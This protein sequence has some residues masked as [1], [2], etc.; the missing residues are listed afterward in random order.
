VKEHVGSYEVVRVLARGGMAV[1]YLAVQPTLDRQVALKRLQLETTDPTLAQR[2]VREAKLAA[3]LD[4]PNVVTLFDFFEDGGVPYIAMEYVSGGSLRRLVGHL[5]LPQVFGVLEGVLAGLSHAETRGI[6]HRDL[7][8]ENVLLTRAGGVKIA[9]FGIA[10]AYNALTPS[11]TKTDSAIGTPSYMAPEQVTGDPL[12][13]YTDL[14]A[15]GVIAYELLSGHPPFNTGTPPVAVLYRHVHTPPPPLAELAPDTPKPVCEWAEWLLEKAP[16]ERPASAAAASQALEEIAVETLGPY[17]RRSAAIKPD[18]APVPT[19]ATAVVSTAAP[20]T[21]TTRVERR[22]RR[23][24]RAVLAGVA[25]AAAGAATAGVLIATDNTPTAEAPGAVPAAAA[26]P[27]DFD[28]DGRRELVLGMP[29]SGPSGAGV[30]ATWDGRRASTV[31]TAGDAEIRAPFNGEE[32]FGTSLA[33]SDFNQDGY[34]DL[35]VSVPGRQLVTV[36]YGTSKGLK[37]ADVQRIGTSEMRLP[38]DTG[39]FGSRLVGADFNDDGF[40][41]LV[42]GAPGA[43]PNGTVSSGSLL[44]MF[45]GKDGISTSDT[46]VLPR[47]GELLQF[48]TKLRAGDVDGDRHID[49]VE[50]APDTPR[51]HLTFCPG[52]EDGPTKCRVVTDSLGTSALAVADLTGDGRDDIVQGDHID[53]QAQAT[54]APPSGG[55]IRIWRGRRNGPS[56]TPLTLTQATPNIPGAE[57]S[58]DGFGFTVDTADLDGDSLADIIVG[59]PFDDGGTGSLAIIHGGRGGYALGG[60]TRFQK[61]LGVSG[62]GEPGDRLGWAVSA[63]DF[64]GDDRVDIAV[65]VPGAKRLR[66]AVFVLERSK[67]LFAP[68]DTDVVWP[69]RG[70]KGV[71]SPEIGSIRL[72][73]ADGA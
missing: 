18:A 32:R 56:A 5:S 19:L 34:A 59:V 13:P 30:V 55:E 16:E 20:E 54:G 65:G 69:L 67:G 1:V 29:G 2:F 35:A 49:L 47:P 40:G 61:G 48:G 8:P 12:G 68:D 7:K 57:G 41:D 31:V 37:D 71:R 52:A 73:R 38:E 27:Y 66:D 62:Q 11:L 60:N 58:G 63:L 10:R 4:H 22:P 17:W 15:L 24:R 28:G 33:S 42:V 53:E 6:A 26:A 9:D 25:L 44:I 45:G 46:R 64:N 36:I 51:G 70:L 50:G 72:G 39:R 14:Y 21:P 43:D 23:G 3:G